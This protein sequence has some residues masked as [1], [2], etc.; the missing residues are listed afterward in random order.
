VEEKFF[1]VA[2]VNIFVSPKAMRAILILLCL[3][4][5]VTVSHAQSSKRRK[6]KQP[7]TFEKKNPSLE[8]QASS[9]E[10]YTPYAERAT[11]SKK[12]SVKQKDKTGKY[13]A[14]Q[15]FYARMAA[16]QKKRE[17]SEKMMEKPQYSDPMY[18]GHRRPPKKRSPGKM[19]FCKECGIK[20]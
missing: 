2:A 6:K 19:K 10:P 17:Q 9:L 1:Q 5:T 11:T 18:F 16:V 8:R 12:K 7:A 14:Q 13:D 15:E 20:H 3:T 4:L